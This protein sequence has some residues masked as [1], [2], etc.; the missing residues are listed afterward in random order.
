MDDAPFGDGQL[1]RSR[2]R[3]NP[4]R[5]AAFRGRVPPVSNGPRR[6]SRS[7][8]SPRPES[9]GGRLRPARWR[10]AG[11]QASTHCHGSGLSLWPHESKRVLSTEHMAV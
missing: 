1:D 6:C 5:H 8:L 4:L 9:L 11:P 7:R 10:H 3:L 2:Q